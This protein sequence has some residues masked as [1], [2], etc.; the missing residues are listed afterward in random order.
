MEDPIR[1]SDGEDDAAKRLMLSMRDEKPPEGAMNRAL[2]AVGVT[3][4]AVVTTGS[5]LGT[6]ATSAGKSLTWLALKWVGAGA[7]LG[8]AVGTGATLVQPAPTT[9][10]VSTTS[11][12]VTLLPKPVVTATFTTKARE[13]TA[14]DPAERP[15]SRAVSPSAKEEVPPVAPPDTLPREVEL[16]DD[17]RASL[18]RGA[19]NDALGALDR[20]AREFPRGRLSTEAFV[21]RIDALTRAG[22]SAEAKSLAEGF[23]RANPGSPH[24]ARIQKSIGK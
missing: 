17:A 24:A 13:I 8:L 23:L 18:R 21:L 10:A 12:T 2:L 16:L 9:K 6:G 7:V 5:A 3:T 4:A 1:F 14:P 19:A 22:R 20:Y 11:S 15:A